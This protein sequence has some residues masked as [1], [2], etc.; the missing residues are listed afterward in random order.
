MSTRALIFDLDGTLTDPF[1]GISRSYLHALAAI[2]RDPLPENTLRALIGPP[3]QH[4][5]AQLCGDEPHLIAAAVQA[6]RARYAD[7][8][9]FENSVYT[10]IPEMLAALAQSFTLYV[11]TSKPTT[12][13]ERILAHFDLARYF[14]RVYGITLD[15]T[16]H[17]KSALLAELLEREGLAAADAIMIGD[18]TFDAEAA[19]STGVPFI[20]VLWGFGSSAE[21]QA[22]GATTYVATPDELAREIAAI[23]ARKRP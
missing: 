23:S 10:G 20:G 15:V 21:F 14:A 19:L 4:A 16:S 5:F 12:F 1:V 3:I 6:Y 18:R 22:A 8:G 9:L 11:C 2:G 13:A 7:V 17:D